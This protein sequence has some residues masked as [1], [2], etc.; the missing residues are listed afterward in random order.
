MFV[1]SWNEQKSKEMD[2]FFEEKDGHLMPIN[3]DS[4]KLCQAYQSLEGFQCIEF[5]SDPN[6]RDGPLFTQQ[7][8]EEFLAT[9]NERFKIV[10]RSKHII[11]TCIHGFI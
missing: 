8:L 6:N 9:A 10:R 1:A 3:P 11:I 7:N 2:V 4:V 5:K